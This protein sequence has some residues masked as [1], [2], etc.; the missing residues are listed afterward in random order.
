MLIIYTPSFVVGSAAV[1]SAVADGTLRVGGRGA[2]VSLLVLLH[3][4]KR[5]A[6]ALALHKVRP[7]YV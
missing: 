6:E 2:I 4:A 1:A 5:C 7:L 3:F